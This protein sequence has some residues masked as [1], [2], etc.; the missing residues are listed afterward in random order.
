M[1]PEDVALSACRTFL[2][3]ARLGE[4]QLPDSAALWKL[5]CVI[6]LTK[7]SEQVRFHRR[8]QRDVG[9]EVRLDRPST[10]SGGFD[11]PGRPGSD[12]AEVITDQFA[13][14]LA[15]L[16]DNK[17]EVVTLKLQN[18]TNDEIA[19]RLNSSERTVRRVLERVTARLQLVS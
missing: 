9:Q 5:L 15:S 12:E 4:F 8:K 11:L 17:R 16:P 19:D 1:G 18:L 10:D 6:T 14:L 7:A 13:V 2:R 3:R